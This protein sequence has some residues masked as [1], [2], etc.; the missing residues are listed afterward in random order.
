MRIGLEGKAVL[1]TGAAQGVGAAVARAAAAAGAEALFLTDRAADRLET[2]RG[3]IE[4]AGANAAAMVA[5]LEDAEAPERVIEA[6]RGRMGRIDALVNAAGL[7]DR[8]AIIDATPA[9]WERMMAVNARA[10][11]FLMQGATD[12]MR[13][14]AAPGAIVN[15]LSVNG[16]CGAPELAVYSATKGALATLTRNAANANLSERIRVN[17]I[18]LGWAETPAEARMQAEVLGQ[19]AGWAETAARHLPLGRLLQP[20]EAARLAVFLLGDFS[21]PL[22]GALIDLDQHVLGAPAP[23][24]GGHGR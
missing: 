14:R 18:N 24:I 1:V 22:T 16:H 7:T 20:D 11:F 10:P 6:A 8:A 23:G 15:I 5:D 17:G 4:N 19:G 21:A 3:A 12:D 9:I 13:A 2:T